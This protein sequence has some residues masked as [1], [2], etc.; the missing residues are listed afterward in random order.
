MRKAAYLCPTCGSAFKLA[1]T[2]R[3]H[4][5]KC[6]LSQVADSGDDGGGGH[7][8]EQSVAFQVRREN[9]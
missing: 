4:Q 3:K 6:G 9:N 8:E 1:P 7:E 5:A 2:F